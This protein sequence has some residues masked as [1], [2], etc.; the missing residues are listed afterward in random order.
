MLDFFKDYTH[1]FTDICKLD[2]TTYVTSYINH[3]IEM[4]PQYSKILFTMRSNLYNLAIKKTATQ[5]AIYDIVKDYKTQ[6]NEALMPS[7]RYLNEVLQKMFSSKPHL[8]NNSLAFQSM[9]DMLSPLQANNN[10]SI[11]D[12]YPTVHSH[13]T[14]SQNALSDAKCNIS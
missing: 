4:L 9:S 2:S 6:L 7:F 14:Q 13:I 10:L 8:R 5:E 1:F 12:F 11:S 3:T